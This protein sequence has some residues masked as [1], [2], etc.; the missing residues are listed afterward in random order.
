L[1]G[2]SRLEDGD[3][4]FLL[5]EQSLLRRALREKNHFI[6]NG[7]VIALD[8]K[9]DI[10]AIRIHWADPTRRRL[11]CST[12]LATA[13]PW[14]NKQGFMEDIPS[15]AIAGAKGGLTTLGFGCA[16]VSTK[17]RRAS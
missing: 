6:R 10:N 12:G 4:K 15:G 9:E 11:R 7:L 16:P 13:T 3:L 8:K 2:F 17:I 1:T 5:E 14:T